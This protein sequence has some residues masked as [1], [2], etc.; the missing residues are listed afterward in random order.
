M[1]RAEVLS[2][3]SRSIRITAAALK[4]PLRLRS[5]EVTRDRGVNRSRANA[6]PNGLEQRTAPRPRQGEHQ[7]DLDQPLRLEQ[8]G[9]DRAIPRLEQLAQRDRAFRVER[10]ACREL[11]R[12]LAKRLADDLQVRR[13]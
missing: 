4:G 10:Q 1:L 6:P 9:A 13:Q 11:T 3:T 7:D 12:Q 8:H 5:D 2:C